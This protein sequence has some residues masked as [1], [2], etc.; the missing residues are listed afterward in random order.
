MASATEAMRASTAA[1]SPILL[2]VLTMTTCC[3]DL[4]RQMKPPDFYFE[5][6]E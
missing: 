2:L 5:P 6:L 3:E 1:M 4:T